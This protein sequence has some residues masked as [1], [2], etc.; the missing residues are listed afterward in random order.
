VQRFG[1]ALNLHVH[2]HAVVADAVFIDDGEAVRAVPVPPPSDA[3]V[4]A[5]VARVARRLNALERRLRREVSAEPAP[6]ALAVEQLQGIQ[7]A[8]VVSVH[9]KV[10]RKALALGDLT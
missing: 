8:L 6:D 5:V 3:E 4:R 1:G 7:G 10:E 9:R 2:L